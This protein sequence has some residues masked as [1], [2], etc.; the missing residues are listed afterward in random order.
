MGV[1]HSEN[2]KKKNKDKEKNKEGQETNGDST[3]LKSA[4]NR[5]NQLNTEYDINIINT[6]S[7]Q[8][9]KYTIKS[10]QIL[11]QILKNAYNY[12]PNSDFTL[13]FENSKTINTNKKDEEF[14]YLIKEVFGND[15][16]EKINMKYT[17]KGLDITENEIQ[18]YKDN[19]K[20]IGSAIMDINESFGIITYE[21]SSK[22]ISSYKYKISEYPS[23]NTFNNFTAYCNARNCLYFSG[24]ENE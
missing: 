11:S 24:G 16:P 17:Y 6:S 15:I 18:A 2:S 12:N 7:N 1:C 20:I 4:Y 8:E 10:D 9:I 13:E 3:K 21:I 5:F 22:K 23:L 14:G 19:N